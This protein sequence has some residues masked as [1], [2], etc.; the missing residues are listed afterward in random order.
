MSTPCDDN[1]LFT[2][3]DKTGD[4]YTIHRRFGVLQLDDGTPVDQLDD[5]NFRIN[6]NPPIDASIEHYTDTE[7]DEED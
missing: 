4:E 2:V 6:T 1:E 5:V 3:Y 7:L